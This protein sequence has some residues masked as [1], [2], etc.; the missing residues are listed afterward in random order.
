[1]ATKR[2]IT[3]TPVSP[4]VLR[5]HM[6]MAW[7]ELTKRT[8]T[9]QT[10]LDDPSQVQVSPHYEPPGKQQVAL[11]M[12]QWGAE[13]GGGDQFKTPQP[14][15][16]QKMTYNYNLTGVK[17]PG[18]TKDQYKTD[19]FF[20]ATFEVFDAHTAQGYIDRGGGLVELLES[21]GVTTKIRF[22]PDHWAC[23]FRSFPTLLEGCLF[24]LRNL[25][26]NYNEAWFALTTFTDGSNLGA[27][28]TFVDRLAAKR[29]FTASK[30][31]YLT[32]L[33][34]FYTEFTDVDASVWDEAFQFAETQRH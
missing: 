33:S 34:K 24:H 1:M 27:V 4:V 8:A 10:S 32:N 20:A 29:Y 22:K 12:S 7:E 21:D 25:R 16:K 23:A 3:A 18:P 19:Y 30:K 31:D 28:N 14:G 6:I 13:T 15:E 5:R 9:T 2:E 26:D 17:H 11:I